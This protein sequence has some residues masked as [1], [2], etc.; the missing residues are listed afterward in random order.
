MLVTPENRVKYI[1]SF[2]KIHPTNMETRIYRDKNIQQ[3]RK[4]QQEIGMCGIF[5]YVTT[6]EEALG[7]I[8]IS[9]AERLTYRGGHPRT[10]GRG[11]GRPRSGRQWFPILDRP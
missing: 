7:P 6:N 5:G 4:S 2:R 9:A 3:V 11:R 10:V 1:Y 8:L